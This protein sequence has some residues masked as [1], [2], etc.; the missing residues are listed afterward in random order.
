MLSNNF[1][2]FLLSCSLFS[3]T[4]HFPSNCSSFSSMAPKK[5]PTLPT[6]HG[7]NAIHVPTERCTWSAHPIM[8]EYFWDKALKDLVEAGSPFAYKSSD[9]FMS[10]VPLNKQTFQ[11]LFHDNDDGE[12]A[13]IPPRSILRCE[14]K[15]RMSWSATS[16]E[17][18]AHR[19]QFFDK[20]AGHILAQPGRKDY[21]TTSGFWG[22]KP[23]KEMT[24][25][26]KSIDLEF[27]MSSWSI[28]IH[29]FVVA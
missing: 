12:G 6:V 21:S 17:T 5:R 19:N 11:T 20:W 28:G 1:L 27:L 16:F 25:D 23:V 9:S 14:T 26:R 3:L 15:G 8:K 7:F 13:T 22:N 10:R 29:T 4:F 2:A 18:K 24:V